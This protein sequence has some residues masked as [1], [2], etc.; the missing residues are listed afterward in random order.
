MGLIHAELK[1]SNAAK[2]HLAEIV[3][4]ALVDTGA[5]QLCIPER[6]A[7]QL[8]L[9]EVYRRDVTFADG[10]RK[11]VPYVGPIHCKFG[12]RGCMI[13]AF[14]VVGDRM[15][16]GALPMEDMD[17]VISPLDGTVKPNPRAPN[18]PSAIVM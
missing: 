14:V 9:D 3:E 12:N 10:S 13:G 5:A 18:I 16:M 4:Q 11:S 15:L 1:L 17:L 6:I 2:P 8:E 7:I